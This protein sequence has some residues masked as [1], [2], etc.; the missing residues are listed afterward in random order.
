MMIHS[1]D[2]T[3]V[4]ID[5]N[6]QYIDGHTEGDGTAPSTPL[7]NFPTTLS[8]GVIYLVRR[9]I[10]KYAANM[11]QGTNNG[12]ITSLVIWGMPKQ[13]EDHWDDVPLVAQNAWA[14]ANSPR[15]Y[16]LF[17]E[18]TAHTLELSSAKNI[19]LFNFVFMDEH[20][21]S[22][23]CYCIC[24]GSSFGCNFHAKNMYFRASTDWLNSANHDR[25]N[26]Y[27]GSRWISLDGDTMAH[28]VVIEN[29]TMDSYNGNGGPNFRL[30]YCEYIDIH[31]CVVN[32]TQCWDS[33]SI[34]EW[35]EYNNLDRYQYRAPIVTVKNC[36]TNFYYNNQTECYC[37][38]TFSGWCCYAMISNV[39]Y[40]LADTQFFNCYNNNLCL[41]PVIDIGLQSPGSIIDGVTVN[42]PSIQGGYSQA[43]NISYRQDD[44]TIWYPTFGQYTT[45]K[46]ITINMCQDSPTYSDYSN[47]TNGNVF[48]TDNDSAGLL[49]C[50]RSGSR[51]RPSSSDYLLQNINI[52]APRGRALVVDNALLDMKNNNIQGGVSCYGS[53]GKIGSIST[54]Y[55]GYVFNDNGANLIYIGTITCNRQNPSWEY[56]G[57]YAIHPSWKSNILCTTCNVIFMTSGINTD[58]LLTRCSYICT[59]DQKTGNYTV[60]NRR[61]F[62]KTWSVNR[63]GSVGGCTLKLY[64]E[65][66]EDWAFPLLIGG[67][68]FKGVTK[69]VTAGSHTATIYLTMYGYN[70]FTQIKDRFKVRIKLPDG[71][72]VYSQQ[73]NWS[74]DETSVYENIEDNTSYKLEIPFEVAEAGDVEFEYQ[75]SWFRIGGATYLDP[76]PIIS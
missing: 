65:T 47:H 20:T 3:F 75:F 42:F 11:S 31:D 41:R 71:T 8:E 17:K 24:S 58:Y 5:P 38:R 61:S 27:S 40:K 13:G 26:N 23:D 37:R 36:I 12:G 22:S 62:C 6:D 69:A 45:V 43:I 28:S 51:S 39:T 48:Y 16:V 60:R 67:E 32:M 34:F 74:V 55:P 10:F 15:A 52:T 72:S 73:G 14:D 53:M 7:W 49:R 64:N 56:N 63:I 50:V 2:R 33:S 44:D 30:Y 21:N 70:D 59:N 25:P 9:S 66:D 57:Q 54:W 76:H 18:E 35:N 68:P 1:L 19:E 4:Y 29:C 46:N